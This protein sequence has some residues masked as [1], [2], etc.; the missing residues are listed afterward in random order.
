MSSLLWPGMPEGAVISYLLLKESSSY[1]EMRV[2]LK[3]SPDAT[4]V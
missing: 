2:E 1:L 3:L 4:L